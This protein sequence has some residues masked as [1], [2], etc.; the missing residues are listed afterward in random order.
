MVTARACPT[1]ALNVVAL[2]RRFGFLLSVLVG[3]K[4]GEPAR[5]ARV[6]AVK[7]RAVVPFDHGNARPHDAGKLKDGDGRTS[8]ERV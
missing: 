6:G 2:R 4:G 8:G 7:Q 3:F 5:D 1:S